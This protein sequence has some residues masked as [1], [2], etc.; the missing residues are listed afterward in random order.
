[1]EL[2]GCWSGAK[3]LSLVLFAR[4]CSRNGKSVA[5]T[6]ALEFSKTVCTLVRNCG[7]IYFT[8]SCVRLKR[9]YLKLSLS[10]QCISSVN[11]LPFSCGLVSGTVISAGGGITS[12]SPIY[13]SMLF[14]CMNSKLESDI[15]G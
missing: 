6:P 14:L 3:Q 1:M 5:L 13:E 10:L 9:F 11:Q 2:P 12:S 8:M 7:T 4:G 15:S